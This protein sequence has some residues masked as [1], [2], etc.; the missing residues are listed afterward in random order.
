M[1]DKCVMTNIKPKLKLAPMVT[2]F[3]NSMFRFQMNSHSRM[4]K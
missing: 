3:L 2:L 4:A 1:D